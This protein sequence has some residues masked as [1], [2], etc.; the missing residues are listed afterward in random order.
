M[1]SEKVRKIERHAFFALGKYILLSL[2]LQAVVW[3]QRQ[4]Q[5]RCPTLSDATWQHQALTHVQYFHVA[6]LLTTAVVGIIGII[7]DSQ[8]WQALIAANTSHMLSFWCLCVRCM[9]PWVAVTCHCLSCL[10]RDFFLQLLSSS[11]F[12]QL[13]SHVL[14]P[15][16]LLVSCIVSSEID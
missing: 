10:L 12:C 1:S 11:Y 2:L 9:S 15:K 14:M 7:N 5:P 4:R 3:G 8:C 13:L 16:F 6:K